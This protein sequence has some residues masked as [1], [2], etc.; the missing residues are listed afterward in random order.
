MEFGKKSKHESWFDGE[1]KSS[2]TEYSIPILVKDK[3]TVM[4]EILKA[5]ELVTN[6]ETCDITIMIKADPKTYDFRLLTKVY[7]IQE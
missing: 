7:T 6:K 3:N 5:L 2:K 4:S 1:L